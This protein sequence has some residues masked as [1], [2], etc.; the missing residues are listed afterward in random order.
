[1]PR[2]RENLDNMCGQC[3]R[4]LTRAARPCLP[5]SHGAGR[6]CVDGEALV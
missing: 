5:A 6:T 1:M 3:A 4:V 2:Y